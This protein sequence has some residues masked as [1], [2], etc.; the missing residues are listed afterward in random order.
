[1]IT[2]LLLNSLIVLGF[3]N[4]GKTKNEKEEAEFEARFLWTQNADKKAEEK[5]KKP[6][7]LGSKKKK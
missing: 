1:M 3:Y 7:A 6:A 2:I 5:N 4:Q